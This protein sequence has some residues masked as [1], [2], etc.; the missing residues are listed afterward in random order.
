VLG[1]AQVCVSSS[2]RASWTESSLTLQRGGFAQSAWL[3]R[4]KVHEALRQD[5]E[6]AQMVEA[7][8]A[9]KLQVTDNVMHFDCNLNEPVACCHASR[10]IPAWHGDVKI[11]LGCKNEREPRMCPDESEPCGTDPIFI[12]HI[13]KCLPSIWGKD[14]AALPEPVFPPPKPMGMP[15]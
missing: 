4:L 12:Q 13:I 3:C 9:E 15:L 10:C 1:W 5:R 2:D 14:V 6:T 8:S 7:S 11:R